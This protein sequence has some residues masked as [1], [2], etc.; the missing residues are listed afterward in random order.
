MHFLYLSVTKELAWERLF[1]IKLSLL[2]NSGGKLK[3][4]HHCFATPNGII[5][6]LRWYSGKESACQHRR[7]RFDPWVTK[8]PLEKGM[9]TH[10]SILV[11]E[12]PWMEEFGK[13]QF[14]GW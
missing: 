10:S 14:K 3:W 12:I 2:I 7:C 6:L 13:L 11:R 4:K 5:G 1:F 8:I 9:T